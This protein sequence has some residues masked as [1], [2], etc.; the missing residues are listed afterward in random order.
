MCEVIKVLMTKDTEEE[1]WSWIA[2][3]ILL[4]TWTTLLIVCFYFSFF[5]HTILFHILLLCSC[6]F[7]KCSVTY[8]RLLNRGF[9]TV[10]VKR[11]SY[12]HIIFACG[13]HL[14][15][16]NMYDMVAFCFNQMSGCVVFNHY[17]FNPNYLEFH[18]YFI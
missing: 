12:G 7:F 10:L 5:P 1:T 18:Y 2:R 17:C 4:D 3:D 14:I 15:G 13:L 11:P 16:F 8:Q 6:K 9:M